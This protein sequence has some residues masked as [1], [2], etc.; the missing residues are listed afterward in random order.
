MKSERYQFQHLLVKK[1]GNIIKEKHILLKFIQAK[2]NSFKG[3]I[4]TK[5][6][7]HEDSVT[8]LAAFP[9][10]K[11]AS[12]SMDKTIRIWDMNTNETMYSGDF[13]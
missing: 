13:R 12:G 10:G 4:L 3:E 8:C 2:V 6:E 5:L 9:D 7:D 1:V 11:L